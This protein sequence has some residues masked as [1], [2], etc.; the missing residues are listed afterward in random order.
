SSR[1]VVR[2]GRKLN[3]KTA[4]GMLTWSHYSFKQRLLAKAR[5]LGDR[6]KVVIVDE[7]YTSKT[8]TGCGWLHHRL[9]GNKL[10]KCGQCG[11]EIGRDHNG[12]RNILL[13]NASNFG[14]HVTSRRPSAG[15]VEA[16]LL[17]SH[18]GALLA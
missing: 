16:T 14:L 15:G 5:A 17:A 7:S 6:C 11:L 3:S 1:M 13:K 8:C 10:F 12:A 9:G 2:K 18:H 4:R